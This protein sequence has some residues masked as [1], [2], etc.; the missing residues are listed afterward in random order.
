MIVNY[1]KNILKGIIAAKF[2]VNFAEW[3][4]WSR[5]QRIEV[6]KVRVGNHVNYGSIK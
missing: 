4:L 3:F 5:M 1:I 2:S 6:R